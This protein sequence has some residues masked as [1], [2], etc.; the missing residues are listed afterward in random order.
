MIIMTSW[1]TGG[2]RTK[3]PESKRK[4]ITSDQQ[5]QGVGYIPLETNK[6]LSETHMQS[7]DE[8]YFIM[9]QMHLLAV[10]FIGGTCLWMMHR[11]R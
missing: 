11:N 4:G 1:G 10:F 2:G 8:D 7:P 6:T 3:Y 5:R 9:M